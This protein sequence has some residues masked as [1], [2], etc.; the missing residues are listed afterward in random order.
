M[1]LAKLLALLS[2]L[3]LAASAG[4]CGDSS[5]GSG[6]PT[7][8]VADTRGVVASASDCTSFGPGTVEACAAAIEKAVAKHEATAP[9][10]T[11]L[12]ACEAST[13]ADKCERAQSGLYR[14]KLSAFIVTLGAETHAEPLYPVKEGAA[15]FLTA[16]KSV[17]LTTDRSYTFSR[18]AVSVAQQQSGPDKKRRGLGL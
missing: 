9:T 15:G 2:L 17:L 1:R 7:K 14:P 4:G 8:P 6:A 16:G 10:F 12:D 13:G 18:L 3:G 5:S 11:D